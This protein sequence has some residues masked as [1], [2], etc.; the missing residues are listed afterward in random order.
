M[1]SRRQIW[2][3]PRLAAWTGLYIAILASWL[4][5]LA[6]NYFGGAAAFSDVPPG[7]WEALCIS[8]GEVRLAPLVVMWALMAV[9]MMAPTFVPTFRTFL[10][11]P[12]AANSG[13]RDALVLMA[14]FLAIWFA[15]SIGGAAA[16]QQLSRAAVVAP[17]G[18]SVSDG[19]TAALFLAAGIYQ[20]SHLKA[21]CLSRCRRPLAFFMERWRPGRYGAM[22]LGAELGLACLGCC[23]ALMLLAFVGGT[24]NLVWMGLATLFMTF[25]KLPEIG[26]W[27][28]GPAGAALIVAG[29]W[30][31]ARWAGLT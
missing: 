20:F 16:Q 11:L 13:G 24:M 30:M 25:E 18:Q 21:A 8:A 28:T 1:N 23:W 10:D 22:R 7:L 26:R 6:M 9:A 19:L 12:A 4:A 5:L 17:T 3:S 14:G 29:L 27:L 15:A 31:T 2:L